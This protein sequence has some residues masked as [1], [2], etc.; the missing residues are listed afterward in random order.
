MHGL[1]PA[2]HQL[3]GTEDEGGK[4]RGEGARSSIL[5]ITAREKLQKVFGH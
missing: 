5:Q 3:C 2:L 4:G 1:Q